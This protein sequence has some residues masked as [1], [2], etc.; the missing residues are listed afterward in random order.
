MH[1]GSTL[2]GRHILLPTIGINFLTLLCKDLYPANRARMRSRI[3]CSFRHLPQFSSFASNS[4]ALCW[5][6]RTVEERWRPLK[7]TV[8][9][10]VNRTRSIA[11][12]LWR[13]SNPDAAV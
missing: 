5:S 4:S 11:L 12:A 6:V 8:L 9:P 13:S 3:G 2:R 1:T 7:P 10:W